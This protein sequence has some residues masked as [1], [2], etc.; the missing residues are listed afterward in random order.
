M[1]T[2]KDYE[3]SIN[4][5][6]VLFT[7]DRHFPLIA[8]SAPGSLIISPDGHIGLIGGLA[9][10]EFISPL[11]DTEIQSVKQAPMILVAES[12]S[13]SN[14]VRQYIVKIYQPVIQ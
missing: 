4:S 3:L 5:K 9:E 10:V 11:S 7:F 1:T 14:Q 2:I 13:A 12:D 6:G 8:S